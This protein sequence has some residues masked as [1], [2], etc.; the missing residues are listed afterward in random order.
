MK[1]LTIAT[2][3]L[4]TMITLS[5]CKKVGNMELSGKTQALANMVSGQHAYFIPTRFGLDRANL[6]QADGDAN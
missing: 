2:V 1:K 4:G 6:G 5:Y 3:I